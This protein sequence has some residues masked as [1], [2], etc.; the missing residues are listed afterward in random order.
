RPGPGYVVH[1]GARTVVHGRDRGLAGHTGLDGSPRRRLAAPVE[2]AA[3]ARTRHRR[4]AHRLRRA[5]GHRD[6]LTKMRCST[7]G[8]PPGAGRA[9][10]P[11]PPTA[12]PTST[13]AAAPPPP[14]HI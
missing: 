11:P 6:P 9:R 13:P 8:A 12:A 7:A 2:R 5:T 4:R 14:R 1:P 10:L 3:M